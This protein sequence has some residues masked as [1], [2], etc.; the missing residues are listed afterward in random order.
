[1]GKGLSFLLILQN[2]SRLWLSPLFIGFSKDCNTI[3][4]ILHPIS[5]RMISLRCG[6]AFG[7]L[8]LPWERESSLAN[9]I[10]R[11]SIQPDDSSLF[12]FSSRCLVR[13]SVCPSVWLA[14]SKSREKCNF[15]TYLPIRQYIL[16]LF[17]LFPFFPF[18][19]SFSPSSLFFFCSCWKEIHFSLSFL[20]GKRRKKERK[21]EREEEEEKRRPYLV[22]SGLMSARI[23][24][25]REI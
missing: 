8:G 5:L 21:R 15:S 20:G 7:K 23:K 22:I 11:D 1:M 12:P 6:K 9:S 25:G 14:V 19:L 4:K 24:R 2:F 18:F 3:L 13:L 10:S 16:L 17:F